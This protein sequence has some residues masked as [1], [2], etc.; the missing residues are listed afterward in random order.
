LLALLHKLD[1]PDS[2]RTI[3]GRY[4]YVDG[5][6]TPPN[7]AYELVCEDDAQHYIAREPPGEMHPDTEAFIQGEKNA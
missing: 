4:L 3:G 1:M 2:Q 6:L 5:K 7:V